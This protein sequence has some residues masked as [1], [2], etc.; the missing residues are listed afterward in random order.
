MRKN[1]EEPQDVRKSERPNDTDSTFSY[2]MNA[3]SEGFVTHK[4]KP[5]IPLRD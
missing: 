5:S 4:G 1:P 2:F 3:E